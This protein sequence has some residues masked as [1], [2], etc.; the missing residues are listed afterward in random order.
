MREMRNFK[1]R[2]FF[3]V[4]LYFS[5]LARALRARL[6]KKIV[7]TARIARYPRVCTRLRANQ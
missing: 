6:P 4:P 7:G 1:W 5:F 2:G 3:V